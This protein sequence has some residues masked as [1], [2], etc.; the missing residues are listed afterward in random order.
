MRCVMNITLYLVFAGLCMHFTGYFWLL[1]VI[2]AFYILVHPSHKS[3]T[4]TINIIFS[5]AGSA[6]Q[7]I[8]SPLHFPAFPRIILSC[9]NI[10]QN[11]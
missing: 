11:N 8:C 10:Q 4:F 1:L 3:S 6:R 5:S 9:I 2:F 7:N